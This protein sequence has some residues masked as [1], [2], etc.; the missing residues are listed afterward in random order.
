MHVIWNVNAGSVEEFDWVKREFESRNDV[1]FHT[2][3]SVEDA[4]NAVRAAIG[5]GAASIIA[6]GGDGTVSVIINAMQKQS[7]GA[8]LGVIPLGTA[9]EL[10]RTLAMPVD[11]TEALA[12][13]DEGR[14]REIDLA[15][16][17]TPEITRIFSNTSGG[18]NTDRVLSEMDPEI[19]REWK[20]W[21]YIR[22][23]IEIITDL[24]V[25]EVTISCDGAP[26]ETFSVWNLVV[27]NGR[28]AGGGL[29]VAPAA[30]IEDGWLDLVMV[31]DGEPIDI[32]TLGA[33]LL[34]GGYLEDDRTVFRRAKRIEINSD[35]PMVFIADG[36]VLPGHPA[37]YEVLPGAL[38]VFVGPDYTPGSRV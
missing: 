25:Y 26:P 3:Q 29:G 30:D 24:T 17:T 12:V 34:M 13:I 2:T 38:T 10:C 33:K 14:K 1:V 22:Q 23:A 6:C 5:A 9:N 36:E 7:C 19:K 31:L 15:S 35:P 4:Q 27:G 32:P 21:S 18:G 20:A 37:V 16:I 28:T 8:A 11:P